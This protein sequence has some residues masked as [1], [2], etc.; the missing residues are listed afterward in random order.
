M[1]I[2]KNQ[3]ENL[4]ETPVSEPRIRRLMTTQ[5]ICLVL[6]RRFNAVSFQTQKA[7]IFMSFSGKKLRAE[8]ESLGLTIGAVSEKTGISE[9]TIYQ[10]ECGVY[11]MSHIT[12]QLSDFYRQIQQQ[13]DGVNRYFAGFSAI[14]EDKPDPR[15]QRSNLAPNDI[16]NLTKICAERNKKQIQKPVDLFMG[17][18]L[19]FVA[20]VTGDRRVELSQGGAAHESDPDMIFLSARQARV[21]SDWL[22]SAAGYLESKTK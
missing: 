13:R 1:R 8:R 7:R 15:G 10:I 12:Q 18:E 17:N 16:E 19:D 11:G 3:I 21:L 20:S 6:S 5:N 2:R 14:P 22:I 4:D 9:T